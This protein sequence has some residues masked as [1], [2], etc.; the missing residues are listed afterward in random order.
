M[1]LFSIHIFNSLV[2]KYTCLLRKLPHT[3]LMKQNDVHV[4]TEIM[5]VQE[6]FFSAC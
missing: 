6:Q 1:Y 3:W 4:N 5:E 2:S